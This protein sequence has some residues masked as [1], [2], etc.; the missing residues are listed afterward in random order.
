MQKRFKEEYR[1]CVYR[2]NAV[3]PHAKP[4]GRIRTRACRLEA[5]GN[6]RTELEEIN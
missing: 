2:R 6:L 3:P 5:L 4:H 1:R